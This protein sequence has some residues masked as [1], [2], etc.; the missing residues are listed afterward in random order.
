MESQNAELVKKSIHHKLRLFR[1]LGRDGGLGGDR[2]WVLLDKSTKKTQNS[3]A[4]HVTF[5]EL[6]DIEVSDLVLVYGKKW[7]GYFSNGELSPGFHTHDWKNGVFITVSD[8]APTGSGNAP[9][10]GVVI[11][12]GSERER[13]IK[14]NF[15]QKERDSQQSK[16]PDTNVALL[17]YRNRF[18][19]A[20]N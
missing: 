12:I 15:R 7:K 8:G 2:V 19:S 9:K 3:C 18:T 13:K 17:G 6:L 5:P 20:T 11:D 10:H 1:E 4:P 16:S 14:G